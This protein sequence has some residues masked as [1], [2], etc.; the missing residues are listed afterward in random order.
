MWRLEEKDSRI[1]SMQCLRVRISNWLHGVDL[2]ELT[3]IELGWNALAFKD[4]D[5]STLVMKSA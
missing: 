3:S 5:N 2:P 4:S 1:V